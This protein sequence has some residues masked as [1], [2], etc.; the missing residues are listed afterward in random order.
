[1][2]GLPELDKDIKL[3]LKDAEEYCDTHDK[4]TEFMI[5]YMQDMADI[6]YDTVIQYLKED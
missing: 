4:S 1:M 6:D 2:K 3:K 5:Q